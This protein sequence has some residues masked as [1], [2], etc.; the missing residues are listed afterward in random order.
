MHLQCRVTI[1]RLDSLPSRILAAPKPSLRQVRHLQASRH[2]SN[3]PLGPTILTGTRVSS[4]QCASATV[5]V[6]DTTLSAMSTSSTNPC[7]KAVELADGKIAFETYRC[8]PLD[9][10]QT[11]FTSLAAGS[12]YVFD[13]RHALSQAPDILLVIEAIDGTSTL[14]SS[15]TYSVLPETITTTGPIIKEHLEEDAGPYVFPCGWFKV[16]DKPFYID[17]GN[18]PRHTITAPAVVPPGP[19]A[20]DPRPP[21]RPAGM[22]RDLTSSTVE[23]VS[24]GI[25]DAQMTS[26]GLRNAKSGFHQWL[27]ISLVLCLLVWPGFGFALPILQPALQTSTSLPPAP[28]HVTL[29]SVIRSE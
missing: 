8:G 26:H 15:Q 24:T 9:E 4:R 16:W 7:F 1:Q 3:V 22:V 14:P 21:P 11:S 20:T 5:S 29:P 23:G 27:I 10:A 13:G 28:R 6:S 18:A 25:A 12:T 17:C 19:I 2:D